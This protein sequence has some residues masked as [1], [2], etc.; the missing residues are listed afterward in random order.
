M[1]I[2]RLSD[3]KV[4]LSRIALKAATE[5]R[6][7]LDEELDTP[8][9]CYE[10]CHRLGIEV[11]FVEIS[12][13][14]FYR[15]GN[16]PLILISSL[17][18]SVRRHFTCA[19]ELG[20]HRFGH[21]STL[22]EL[23]S[24]EGHAGNNPDEQL[25]D[26]FAGH[27]LMPA[28]GLKRAFRQRSTAIDNPSS[29]SIHTIS[30]EFG[31]GYDTLLTHLTYGLRYMTPTTR[32]RLRNERLHARKLLG[33]SVVAEGVVMLDRHSYLARPI[34]EMGQVLVVP[35]DTI[36]SP[37][38]FNFIAQS[39]LG[40]VLQPIRVGSSEMQLPDASAPTNIR[41]S[42]GQFQGLATYRF[43]SEDDDDGR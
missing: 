11:R 34:V 16:L 43:L 39:Q 9:C 2:P 12:M 7:E 10:V 22:D 24:S 4:E 1:R 13:E 25:V 27:F 20:H 21:G 8:I 33:Q 36:F 42:K 6:L 18:P 31:V 30:A 41:V 3:A 15:R 29:I 14:G 28:L 19:H 26:M 40:N 5:L 38:H 17:R 32:R 37:Q 35:P 23:S